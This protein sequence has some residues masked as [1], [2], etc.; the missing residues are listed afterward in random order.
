[1]YKKLGIKNFYIKNVFFN[2]P[3]KK[4][5]N[6]IYKSCF[7]AFTIFNPNKQFMQNTCGD[8]FL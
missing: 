3:F 7:T 8:V 5:F 2:N 6:T 1:M 4:D